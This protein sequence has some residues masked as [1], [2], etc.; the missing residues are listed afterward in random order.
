V[1]RSR[2]VIE[3]PDITENSL[4]LAARLHHADGSQDRLWWRVPEAWSDAATPWADPFV[5]GLLFPMMQRNAPV[6]IEGRVSPSL[7]ANLELFMKI[8]EGWYPGKYRA[9][10]LTADTEQELPPARE[11]G[12]TLASFSAG[13]DSCFTV[14]RHARALAGRRSRRLGPG[15]FQHGFDVWLSEKDSK[16]IYDQLLAKATTMLAS[17]G[18]PCIPLATNFQ[19]LRLDWAD[20][21]GTQLVSGL[22]L[23]AGRYDAALVANDLPY[24]WLGLPWPSHPIT[25][26]LLGSAGFTVI[27]DGGECSRT[28]KAKVISAWPEAMRHLHVCFS[29][30]SGTSENCCRCEKCVRT[31]LAFRI[32]GCG[33]PAAFKDDVSDR[34]I[35]SMRLPLETRKKRWQQ[36]A[37]EAESAGLGQTGWA[38]AIRTALR[39]YRYRAFRNRLQQPFVPLRN[40]I[41]RLIRGSAMSRRE[42]AESARGEPG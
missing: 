8:W 7:L 18:L 38:R 39:K 11:P 10:T 33:R 22:M 31:M 20:A 42:A 21:W 41:R 28:D 40:A 29:T 23:L 30:V 27:D 1:T 25:N 26:P 16:F 12:T 14:Y 9:V 35:R 3:P 6:H 13:V 24:A 15:V 2:L 37:D 4:C 19:Q 5:V 36:L 34:Q 32:A 17:L